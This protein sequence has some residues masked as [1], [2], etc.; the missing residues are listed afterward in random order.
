MGSSETLAHTGFMIKLTALRQ[1]L[2]TLFCWL[3]R[4][5]KILYEIPSY[6]NVFNVDKLYF[7]QISNTPICTRF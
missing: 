5:N 3:L 7:E 6:F 2:I 4:R 1:N